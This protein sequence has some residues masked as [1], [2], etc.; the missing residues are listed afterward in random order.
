MPQ[1]MTV[2]SVANSLAAGFPVPL[3]GALEATTEAV[4]VTDEAQE[5][6]LSELRA[7][8]ILRPLLDTPVCPRCKATIKSEAAYGCSGC[9]DLFHVRCL[10]RTLDEPRTKTKIELRQ[11]VHSTLCQKCHYIKHIHS[12]EPQIEDP[13]GVTVY[14]QIQLYRVNNRSAADPPPTD[15]QIRV[16]SAAGFWYALLFLGILCIFDVCFMSVF[17]ISTHWCV[18]FSPKC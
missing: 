1:G 14:H 2:S 7:L 4:R 6:K 18:R 10:H 13:M 5:S 16:D 17:V 11:Y 12:S 8:G 3:S 15:M 9:S